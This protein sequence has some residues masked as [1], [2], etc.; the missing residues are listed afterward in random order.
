MREQCELLRLRQGELE[1]ENKKLLMAISELQEE[2]KN[3]KE[4]NYRLTN[5]VERDDRSKSIKE[6][7]L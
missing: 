5:L 1:G 2:V 3:Q 6:K 4:K 7:L